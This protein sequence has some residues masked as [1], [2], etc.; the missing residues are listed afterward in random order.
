[1]RR[2]FFWFERDI[3]KKTILAITGIIIVALLLFTLFNYKTERDS[4]REKLIATKPG[5]IFTFKDL[6][7]NS[8]DTL[9]IMYPYQYFI[10]KEK[11]LTIP[12]IVKEKLRHNSDNDGIITLLFTK[13]HELVDYVSISRMGINFDSINKIS[14]EKLSIPVILPNEE[15]RIWDNRLIYNDLYSYTQITTFVD[16]IQTYQKGIKIKHNEQNYYNTI[17]LETFD[18]TEYMKMFNSLSLDNY[19][20]E[21]YC[22]YY[23]T[24]YGS[25]P[26]IYAKKN[27]EDL[28]INDRDYLYKFLNDKNNRA[29]NHIVPKD[30]E[31]GYFQYL[32]FHEFGE[33]FALSWHELYREKYLICTKN[34]IDKIIKE[35]KN[36][37]LFSCDTLKLNELKGINP[38]PIICLYENYC[39]ITW[40]EINTHFGISRNMYVINRSNP[41]EINLACEVPLL[42]IRP[43]FIY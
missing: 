19:Q 38:E 3:M 25:S 33:Q 30:N 4:I 11:K 13:E 10:L 7:T 26:R 42:E 22:Y 35:Y 37:R 1:M 21:Y 32:F 36:N 5:T 15:F 2:L 31:K 8:W 12:E 40:Y 23:N 6:T 39:F 34:Q 16:K 17:D 41:Y 20:L 27:S 14:D 9:Y 24:L 43:N 28:N 29:Y 18:I